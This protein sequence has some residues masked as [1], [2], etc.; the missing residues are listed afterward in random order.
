[1]EERAAPHRQQATKVPGLQMSAA[2]VL[3]QRMSITHKVFPSRFLSHTSKITDPTLDVLHGVALAFQPAFVWDSPS[4]CTRRQ[5]ALG[6]KLSLVKLEKLHLASS[7]QLLP[8][9][10]SSPP[11]IPLPPLGSSSTGEGDVSCT[12]D[13]RLCLEFAAA[14]I[15]CHLFCS[16]VSPLPGGSLPECARDPPPPFVSMPPSPSPSF[17]ICSAG[18]EV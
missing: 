18:E 15:G 5:M 11:P 2:A 3:P 1:M 6:C 9:I 7:Q 4:A 13:H 12:P 10:K 16:R 14:G 8:F 17:S